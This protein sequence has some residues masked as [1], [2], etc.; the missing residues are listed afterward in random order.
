[1][2]A[3]EFNLP[4]AHPFLHTFPTRGQ[5]HIEHHMYANVPC[6]NLQKLHEAIKHDLPPTPNGIAA[7][8]RE[9]RGA[10]AGHDKAANEKEYRHPISLPSPEQREI[11]QSKMD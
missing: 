11:A 5:F 2:V 9:I 1:M 10:L 8:W 3:H 7:V 4:L 6:Y